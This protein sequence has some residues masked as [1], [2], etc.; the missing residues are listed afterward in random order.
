MPRYFLGLQFN[1]KLTPRSVT[2]I[3]RWCLFL[4][5]RPCTN[6]RE[7]TFPQCRGFLTRALLLL[8][9]PLQSVQIRLF[10][11]ER[12]WVLAAEV[13]Y[14]CGG[15]TQ[16]GAWGKNEQFKMI[17]IDRNRGYWEYCCIMLF[18]LQIQSNLASFLRIFLRKSTFGLSHHWDLVT[19]VRVVDHTWMHGYPTRQFIHVGFLWLCG[20]W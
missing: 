17:L 6:K 8:S 20:Q 4:C 2:L 10:D 7:R 3:S 16:L 12:G 9:G 14:T 13:A 15:G 5:V 18:A 19:G 1:V 11:R